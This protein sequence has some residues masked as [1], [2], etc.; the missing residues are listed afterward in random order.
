MTT[1]EHRHKLPEG[2]F[3]SVYLTITSLI[4]GIVLARGVEVAVTTS[5]PND[6]VWQVFAVN[7][8]VILVVWHHYMYGALYMRWDPNIVD[9]LVPLLLGIAQFV[10]VQYS[11]PL[12]VWWFCPT[13]VIASVGGFAYWYSLRRTEAKFLPED[14]GCRTKYK[15]GLKWLSGMAAGVCGVWLLFCLCVFV[16]LRWTGV[17]GVPHWSL[18][19]M[20]ALLILH[21]VAYE[22]LFHYK[23]R[24]IFEKQS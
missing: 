21:V 8:L 2:P 1:A 18:D 23:I 17:G 9:S 24:P 13:M 6:F 16:W 14:C 15:A 3:A 20:M 12:N 5:A 19:V 7:F 10:M 11:K 22:C 4:Q